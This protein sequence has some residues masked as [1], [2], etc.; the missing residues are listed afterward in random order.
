MGTLNRSLTAAMAESRLCEAWEAGASAAA[1]PERLLP[2]VV[3]ASQTIAAQRAVIHTDATGARACD[4][5]A[6]TRKRLEFRL[7]VRGNLNLNLMVNLNLGYPVV[8]V[9]V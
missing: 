5:E 3:R 6:A 7:R 4:S 8:S 2:M 9:A 1:A